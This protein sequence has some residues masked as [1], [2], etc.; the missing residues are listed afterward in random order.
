MTVPPTTAPGQPHQ[1]APP[2]RPSSQPV[3][4]RL[5]KF[6]PPRPSSAL[7]LRLLFTPPPSL[8]GSHTRGGCPLP[9]P[10]PLLLPG[11]SSASR[12]GPRA[13]RHPAPRTRPPPPPP[14]PL[15]DGRR[16][17]AP[18]SS[19]LP[20]RL[21]RPPRPAPTCSARLAS[22]RL[23]PA[24]PPQPPDKKV[25]AGRPPRQ[26]EPGD[27][28]R[29]NPGGKRGGVKLEGGRLSGMFSPLAFIL[30]PPSRF[31]HGEEGAAEQNCLAVGLNCWWDVGEGRCM[32]GGL[33]VCSVCACSELLQG[34]RLR[35]VN[36]SGR[37]TTGLTFPAELG[38]ESRDGQI[39][40][41]T[42][43]ISVSSRGIFCWRDSQ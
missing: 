14:P 12:T 25:R 11:C 23:P 9:P 21:H 36:R 8:P 3:P 15:G 40:P 27:R 32:V 33:G 43:K 20:R 22:L 19:G 24:Q 34:V 26:R 37:L 17:S 2:A 10:P 6:I 29:E 38:R 16:P 4:R 42:L 18:R 1:P 30:L 31:T 41:H 28:G 7:L 39:T 5:G 35:L 13:G